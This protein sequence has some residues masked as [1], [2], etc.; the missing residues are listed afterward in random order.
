[1][2]AGLISSVVSRKPTPPKTVHSR[3][4]NRSGATTPPEVMR[5]AHEGWK[6]PDPLLPATVATPDAMTPVPTEIAT[7][8]GRLDGTSD[9]SR[10]PC[11]SDLAKLRYSQPARPANVHT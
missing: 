8:P 5:S 4:C 11:T 7:M 10:L 1:M 3:Y 6:S 9:S 2:S